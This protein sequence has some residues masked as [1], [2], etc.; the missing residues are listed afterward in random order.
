[1]IRCVIIDSIQNHPVHLE[2]KYICTDTV[3]GH[4]LFQEVDLRLSFENFTL[5]LSVCDMERIFRARE[6][7]LMDYIHY[8]V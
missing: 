8:G 7:H 4:Y 2:Q 1:M 6:K 3:N 5:R